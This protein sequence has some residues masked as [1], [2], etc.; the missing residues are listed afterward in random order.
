MKRSMIIV[1]PVLLILALSLQ[2]C[3]DDGGASDNPS[4]IGG[5]SNKDH[6]AEY[7]A[8][9]YSGSKIQTVINEYLAISAV[10]GIVQAVEENDYLFPMQPAGEFPTSSQPLGTIDFINC[11]DYVVITKSVTANT[12]NGVLFGMYPTEMA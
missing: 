3:G 9:S 2:G 1:N 6:T 8:H 10:S 4:D 5:Q 7:S 11:H 12:I